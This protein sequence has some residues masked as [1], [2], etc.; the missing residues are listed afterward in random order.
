MKILETIEN[1]IKT[2]KLENQNNNP[3]TSPINN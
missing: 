3:A 2:F 1:N